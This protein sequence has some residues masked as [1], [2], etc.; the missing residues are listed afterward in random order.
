M[1]ISAVRIDASAENWRNLE[2][3]IEFDR[4][5]AHAFGLSQALERGDFSMSACKNF[6]RVTSFLNNPEELQKMKRILRMPGSTIKL[7]GQFI[8]K[9]YTTFYNRA[10]Y[11]K[12]HQEKLE[13]AVTQKARGQPLRLLVTSDAGMGKSRYFLVEILNT[14]V[15]HASDPDFKM[16]IVGNSRW[17][18]TVYSHSTGWFNIKPSS[19]RSRLD[20]AR[21]IAAPLRM[22][23]IICFAYGRDVGTANCSIILVSKLKKC[24]EN[25]CK[26]RCERRVLPPWT[27]QELLEAFIIHPTLPYAWTR[28]G[29]PLA[30]SCA[31]SRVISRSITM[32]AADLGGIF[33]R[34]RDGRSNK[35]ECSCCG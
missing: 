8:W 25:F 20:N 33:R 4:K 23:S 1:P 7:S 28:E 12:L 26:F 17:I 16:L 11:I 32:S 9:K 35:I 14:M 22:R 15:D 34:M 24:Y 19:G 21:L 13:I 31:N 2:S 29:L 27:L 10:A 6:N 5:A 18:A 3:K 30:S